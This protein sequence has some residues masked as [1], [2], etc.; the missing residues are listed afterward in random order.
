MLERKA[1]DQVETVRQLMSEQI[2]VEGRPVVVS[3]EARVKDTPGRPAEETADEETPGRP[4]QQRQQSD[5]VQAL[6]K[7]IQDSKWTQDEYKNHLVYTRR[8]VYQDQTIE[9]QTETLPKTPQITEG[10]V[11]H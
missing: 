6:E 11:T 5:S 7:K 2:L 4:V 8:V 1:P 9:I 3:E 10:T